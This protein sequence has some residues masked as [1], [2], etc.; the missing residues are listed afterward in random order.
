M[1]R[2][3]A[4]VMLA[5]LVCAGCATAG[6]PPEEASPSAA[7]E[8]FSQFGTGES[9]LGDAVALIAAATPASLTE[10]VRLA[11]AADEIGGTGAAGAGIVGTAL[12]RGLY[13][14]SAASAPVNGLSWDRAR[15]ATP[16]LQRIA[17]A[18]ALLDSH[19]APDAA[20]YAA[21]RAKLAEAG[22]LVPR[23]PLPPYFQGL[24]L[25]KSAAPLND[26]R[27]QFESALQRSPG[28]SPAA[29]GLA[30]TIIASGSAPSELPLLQHLASLLPTEPQRFAALAR[31][32]IAAGRPEMGADA[33]A[34][35]L[36][37]APGDPAFALLRAQ[38][39]AAGG[40]WYQSLWVLD[41][42]LRLQPDLS[43]AILLKARLLHENAHN[44]PAALAV[45]ADAEARYPAESSFPELHARILL[46]EGK[47]QE[48][49]TTL[50]R[51]HE[52]A[53]A[54]VGILTLLVSTSVRGLRWN[55]AS[56]WLAQIPAPVRTA[57][58]LRLGW[59][60]STGL[61]DNAQ[62]LA[63]AAQLFQMTRNTDALALEARSMLAA[64]RPSGALVVIDHALLAMD[65]SPPSASELHF[66]RSR[67]GSADPLL[68]LRTALREN[69]DNAEA[70]SAIAEVLA[71][72]RDFR[73]AMEYAKRASALSPGNA[74]LAQKAAEM[75]KLAEAGP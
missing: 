37:R 35:G 51:A 30:R 49:V 21:L 40:D 12:L 33:A 67:A 1:K 5:A 60:I 4:P 47:T 2:K 62:A 63:F 9:L 48:A 31:A 7:Q 53:P 41:A 43:D 11:A 64:G 38:A 65:P 19:A 22:T 52:L 58:H 18:L 61:G 36:L 73:K 26:V 17:P 32:A 56:T 68:E 46:D 28:F 39:L 6:P 44:D 14:E 55:E 66:L 50:Q 74:A 34:Q 25:E 72:Q 3:A 69:P 45:L 15:I 16:F 27:V 57:E 24:A 10:G 13:P 42:L 20:G 75:S 70:L 59:Q 71:G 8:A 23:S 29:A 54:K